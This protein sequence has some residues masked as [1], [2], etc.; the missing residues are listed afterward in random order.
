MKQRITYIV[1]NPDDFNPEQ[2][3]IKDT[4]LT[5][6]GVGAAKEHRITLGLSE[7]PKELQ[8]SLQQWHELH[9]RWASETYYIA[10]APFTS[11]VSPGLHVFFTPGKEG[12]GGDPCLLLK[13]V[14]GDVLKCSDAKES[15]IKLPVLSERFSM[16][17]SSEYYA[18][19]P[20][21]SNLVS[22]I[23]ENLS[24]T[25]STSGKVA[26]ESLLSAS[27]LDID[28]DTISHAIIVNA[29]FSEPKT[30][31]TWTETISLASKEETI[32]IG[33]LNHEPNPDPEDVAFSGFLT[34]LGQD[35][36][37]KPTRFQ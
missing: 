8:K 28:Y 3:S 19:V 24:P 2:L 18:Y 34:V 10:S 22:Y 11:R 25:G 16:S 33:V 5:L 20:A 36:I 29:F 23:Q 9:I 37:P 26:A 31:S 17:A 30:A 21:L 12:S 1:Q 7:L 35:S 27:Y 6:N 14:F 15:F 13:E 4:D 32:E